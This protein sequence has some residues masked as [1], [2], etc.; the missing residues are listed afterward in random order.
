[1]ADKKKELKGNDLEKVSGGRPFL[2]VPV[3]MGNKGTKD[4][5]EL[6]KTEK[7]IEKNLN[8]NKILVNKGGK[9]PQVVV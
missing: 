6:L 9:K 1:M 8:D 2:S 5:R 7:K 4:I 3:L